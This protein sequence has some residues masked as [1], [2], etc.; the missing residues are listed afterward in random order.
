MEIED[1]SMKRTQVEYDH[2]IMIKW[3]CLN[4]CDQ[5]IV[6]KSFWWNEYDFEFLWLYDNECDH[7]WAMG[8]T[9]NWIISHTKS[10]C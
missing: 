9:K 1:C 8:E 2:M 5:M 6:I 10:L 4:D 3:L 7:D